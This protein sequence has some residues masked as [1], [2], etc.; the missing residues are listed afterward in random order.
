[1]TT[2]DSKSSTKSSSPTFCL[3]GSKN[4]VTLTNQSLKQTVLKL[5]FDE[6]AARMLQT[7]QDSQI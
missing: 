2:F 6:A 5:T 1:M 4:D 3:I 7:H